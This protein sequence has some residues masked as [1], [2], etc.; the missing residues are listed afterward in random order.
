MMWLISGI[1]LWSLVHFIPTL[2]RPFRQKL[3]NSWGNGVYRAVF[4]IVVLI[5]IALMV[6]G[7]RH[8]P[9]VS[10]YQLPGWSGPVGFVL[11]IIAFVLF[12]SS[13]HETVIKRYIR[14]P[15]LVSMIVWSISHLI[16]NG[17]T[18]ALVLFGGLGLWALIEIPLINSRDG[19]YKK[20]ASVAL[21]TE[22]KGLAIS[23]AV[24]AV[25][26]FL[27]PYFAGV[28]PIPR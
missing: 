22:I 12:G 13:H 14:H 5:S 15:Q 20:P 18:R 25:A 24:F 10:L 2:A 3:I 23:L 17:S 7:W 16:T 27:H 9:Q 28:A 8:T 21:K 19:A 26:L 4:S 11:M 6:Y 1:L